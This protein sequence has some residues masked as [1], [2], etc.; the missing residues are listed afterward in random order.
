[1]SEPASKNNFVFNILTFKGEI[2]LKLPWQT[3]EFYF[4]VEFQL[5]VVFVN[6]FTV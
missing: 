1:M 5:V 4:D 6:F 3:Y 2:R